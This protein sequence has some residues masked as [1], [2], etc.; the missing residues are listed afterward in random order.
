MSLTKS[1]PDHQ[2]G[3]AYPHEDYKN[4]EPQASKGVCFAMAGKRIFPMVCVDSMSRDNER[5]YGSD[6]YEGQHPV[7]VCA[8]IACKVDTHL[9]V[10]RDH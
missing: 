9:L 1:G 5:E 3:C 8:I 4:L 6:H 2:C 10:L 7:L